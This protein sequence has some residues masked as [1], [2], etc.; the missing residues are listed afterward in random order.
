[1]SN[2][3]WPHRWQPTRLP[4]PWDSPGKNA[5]VGCHFLLQCVKVKSLSKCLT[6]R[7][8]MDC[9][10][11]GTSVHGIFQARVLEWIAIAFSLTLVNFRLFTIL[12]C[13]LVS[14]GFNLH[15][16]DKERERGFFMFKDQLC[17]HFVKPIQICCIFLFWVISWYQ[18]EGFVY[19]Y[20]MWVLWWIYVPQLSQVCG[21]LLIVSF[22]EQK[23]LILL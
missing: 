17:I 19:I 18:F 22:N 21:T 11:R 7:D 16:P 10:P 14:L 6:L 1:M 20:W 3:V 2:S 13:I 8:P 9:S 12:V 4:R 23:L 15:F 5:G